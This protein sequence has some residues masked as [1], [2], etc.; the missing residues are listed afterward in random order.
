MPETAHHVRPATPADVPALLRLKRQLAIQ[1]KAEFALRATERDWLR[2]GFGPRAQFTAFVA[3]DAGAVVGMATASERYYTSWAGATLY[4]QDIYVD[5]AHRGRGI[6]AALLGCVAALALARGSPLVE[7][8]VRNDNP[9]C[10]LYRRV[11][12]QEVDCANYVAAGPALAALARLVDARP[13]SA[14]V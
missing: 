10:R 14:G 6:G 4:I 5:P 3:E 1:E 12:F 9:A 7:L 8:T 2:D 11:G 13:A